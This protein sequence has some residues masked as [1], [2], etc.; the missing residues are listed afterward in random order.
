MSM[1]NPVDNPVFIRHD[2]KC[3][4]RRV[5]R[6]GPDAILWRAFSPFVARLTENFDDGFDYLMKF[7]HLTTRD[8]L[9]REL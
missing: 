4:F 7:D 5:V 2:N 1:I 6:E 9:S 3:P 8:Y